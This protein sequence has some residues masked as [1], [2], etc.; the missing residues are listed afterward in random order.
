ME[1]DEK[2]KYLTWFDVIILSILLFGN[3]IY[4]SSIYFLEGSVTTNG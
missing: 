2:L 4:T 3:G 1:K